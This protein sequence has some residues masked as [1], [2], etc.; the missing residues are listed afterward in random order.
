MKFGIVGAGVIAEY[1]REAIERAEGAE[2]VGVYD[3]FPEASE[4]F[5]ARHGLPSFS[6]IETLVEN[7]VAEVVTIATPSGWHLE[8]S[9]R[10]ME[11]GA[12]VLCEKPLEVTTGKIDR[13][14][15]VS[16]RTG[17]KLGAVLQV[18]TFPGCRTAK[19]TIRDGKLGEILIADAYIKYYRT[20]EYYDADAWRGTFELDGGGAAMNQGIH[21]IDLVNWLVGDAEWVESRCATLGH[22]IEVEDVCHA[23]VGWKGGGRGMIEATTCAKPGFPTRIEIHGTRGSLLLEDS[24]IRRMVIDGEE[25]VAECSGEGAGG[26]ADPTKFSVEG[27][28]VHVENMI[29]AVV[30]NRPPLVNGTEARKSVQLIT[31]LYESSREGK[32]IGLSVSQ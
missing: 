4:K 19:E 1:H 3:K 16:E 28:I 30:K 9:L 10:A 31:S 17:R 18:R 2:L 11:A 22:D 32:R 12:H 13:M 26:H 24:H 29:E 15:A 20:Q 6:S 8:P 21:W 5:A 14:I 25:S 23:V 7:G 27:H